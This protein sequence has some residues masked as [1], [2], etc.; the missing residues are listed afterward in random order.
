MNARR[1]LAVT[2]LVVFVYAAFVLLNDVG[3]LRAALSHFS[4]WTFAAALA[5]AAGNY[6]LRFLKWQ[7]YLLRLR[8]DNVPWVESLVVFLAGFAMSITPAKAGEVFKSALLASARGVSIVRTAPV[9]VADRLTDLIALIMIAVAGSYWFE[10]GRWPAVM[11]SVM[12][13]ALLVFIFVP[14]LGEAVITVA[15]R[16]PLGKKLAPRAREA[17]A[18]LRLLAG[19]S[20][21]VL[22]TI[23]SL[24]A[25]GFECVGLWI[26][27]RGLEHPVSMAVSFFTYAV[28]TIA[29]A[30][31]ML[32]GGVGGTEA[33]METLLLQLG[34]PTMPREAAACAVLLVRFATLWFAV[35]VGAVALAV[36][37]RKYDRNVLG[38][39]SAKPA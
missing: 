6:A 8:V 13:G 38:D 28:A 9:V 11:A 31:M 23:L 21:L 3:K 16:L 10:G 14:S 33:T 22:P 5:L 2:M 26:I 7:Y 36:F 35:G 34:Q 12:V 25:W 24:V 29:G 15:E 17:Y 30:V 39:G 27:L 18:A 19:P 1:I 20:A 37:R 32:P 4:W